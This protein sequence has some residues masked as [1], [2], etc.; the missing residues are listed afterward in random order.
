MKKYLISTISKA[1][2]PFER[3]EEFVENDESL[4]VKI[5]GLGSATSLIAVK[6]LC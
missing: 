3:L 1:K 2:Y 5:E 4:E 6:K